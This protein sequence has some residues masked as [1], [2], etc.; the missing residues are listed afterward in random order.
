MQT[1]AR[2]NYDNYIHWL[3]VI[4]SIFILPCPYLHHCFP[5]SAN[6]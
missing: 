5:F 1:T 3:S 4:L 6:A 2:T